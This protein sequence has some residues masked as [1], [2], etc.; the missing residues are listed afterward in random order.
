MCHRPQ[1]A[2]LT[3]AFYHFFEAQSAPNA[4]YRL[5]AS[6]IIRISQVSDNCGDRQLVAAES[7]NVVDWFVSMH[8]TSAFR[9]RNRE[10]FSESWMHK[11]CLSSS[12]SGK[13][14]TELCQTGLSRPGENLTNRHREAKVTAPLLDST[15]QPLVQTMNRAPFV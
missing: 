10:P 4:R 12:M 11:M 7:E 14:E 8:E 9:G 2:T 15:H 6:L 5:L 3:S 13:K 1:G